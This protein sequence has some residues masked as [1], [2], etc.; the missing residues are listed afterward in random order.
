MMQFQVTYQQKV[1]PKPCAFD[2][3][4]HRV[5][6]EYK[7]L[8][9]QDPP[10]SVLHEF[11]EHNPSFVP[12]AWTPGIKSGHYPIH[13]VLISQPRLPGFDSRT[14]DF[15]WLST[16]SDS[17]YA[18]MIEIERPEKLIFTKKGI[19]TAEFTQARNQLSQWRVWFDTPANEQ[20][21]INDYGIP[22][23]I[24]TSRTMEL[25]LIL[26]YGRRSEF[27]K[28][29]KLSKIRGKQLNGLYEELISFDRL[30]PDVDL[31]DIVTV[32]PM[33]NGRFA[34][35][36]VPETFAI[37]PHSANKMLVLDG[38][39]D[40]IDHNPRIANERAV[41]IKSRITYWR[42][43]I[44]TDGNSFFDGNSFRE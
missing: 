10:E 36:W 24:H 34:V 19:P 4:A 21:F 5:K 30:Q 44:H 25:H 22:T 14:P 13:Q 26:V 16:H 32:T 28:K 35:K 12:G 2:A 38:L 43:W 1:G 39:E 17:W 11:L 33:G 15:L 42:N 6:A 31:Q 18:A 9:M 27:E 7:Q 3:Y 29:P 23:S 37:T 41:F 40:A 20:L 8:L